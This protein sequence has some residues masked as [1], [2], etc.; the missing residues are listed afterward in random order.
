MTIV[1]KRGEGSFTHILDFGEDEKSFDKARCDLDFA[2]GTYKGKPA[3]E[4]RRQLKFDKLKLEQLQVQKVLREAQEEEDQ[5]QQ[6]LLQQL[7]QKMRQITTTTDK[8]LYK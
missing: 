5:R 2:L 4:L 3:R 8:S 6:L 7:Q 1:V